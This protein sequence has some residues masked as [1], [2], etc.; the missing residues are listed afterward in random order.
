MIGIIMRRV[1]A[2]MIDGAFVMLPTALLGWAAVPL[3]KAV[4]G[5]QL[6]G[7][8]RRGGGRVLTSGL[9]AE[10][11]KDSAR[12]SVALL[13]R[14]A[15]TFL[16]ALVLFAM[17]VWLVYD[18]LAHAAFGRTIGKAVFGLRVVRFDGSKPGALCGLIRAAVLIG[19]PAVILLYGWMY[20]LVG[21]TD[22]PL[23]FLVTEWIVFGGL[24]L[25]LLPS[26]RA[27]HD[28]LSFTR[29]CSTR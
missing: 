5:F 2:R 23:T 6:R 3:M 20:A 28:R 7:L 1:G 14:T 18:W 21:R 15:S 9:D 25:V 13:A 11:V 26:H 19:A 17:L 27:L 24:F 12:E 22:R 4:L 29:V 8:V 16:V 10:A